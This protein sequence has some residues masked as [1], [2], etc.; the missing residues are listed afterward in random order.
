MNKSKW[1]SLW[2]AFQSMVKIR[3]ARHGRKDRPVY[4]LVVADSRCPRE[5]RFIEK[6][7]TYNPHS[8]PG[9]VEINTEAAVQWLHKGA[10]PTETA[11]R[12]LSKQGIMLQRHVE[13]G[14]MRGKISQEVANQK[15]D[16]WRNVQRARPA[17]IK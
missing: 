7:G 9:T 2:P 4:S 13:L 17:A 5:G 14:V 6:L 1:L 16:A 3:L 11:R 15:M 8:N 12:L 10:Q